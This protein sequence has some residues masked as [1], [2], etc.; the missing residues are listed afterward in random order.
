MKTKKNKNLLVV[1]AVLIPCLILI[2]FS[3]SIRGGEKSYKIKPEITLPEYRT[4]TAR[5]IDA[6]ESVMD[7]FIDLT[8]KNLTGINTDVKGIANKLVLIDC[9]LTDISTR[10]TR[11]EKALGIEQTEKRVEETPEAKTSNVTNTNKPGLER[12]K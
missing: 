4:D 3:S 11:I 9:K 6:Y 2:G 7:R 12:R 8:E 10:M 5:A 1:G